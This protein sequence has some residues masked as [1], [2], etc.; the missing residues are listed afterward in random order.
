[1]MLRKERKVIAITLVSGFTWWKGMPSADTH[2]WR[3]SGT[4]KWSVWQAAKFLG[5]EV[6]REMWVRDKGRSQSVQLSGQ[7]AKAME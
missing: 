6:R 7:T 4:Y 1:M 5:L 3:G 2:T